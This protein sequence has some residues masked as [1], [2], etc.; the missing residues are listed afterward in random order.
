VISDGLKIRRQDH[1]ERGGEVIN[2]NGGVGWISDVR[3]RSKY[4][5]KI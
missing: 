4:M 3:V 5:R 1:R 2:N